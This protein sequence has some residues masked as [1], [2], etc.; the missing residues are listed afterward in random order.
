[1]THDTP[2]KDLLESKVDWKGEPKNR[3]KTQPLLNHQL[4]TDL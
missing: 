3:F 2:Q 4:F 1:M